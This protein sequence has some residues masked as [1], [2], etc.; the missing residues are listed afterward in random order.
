MDLPQ[1]LLELVEGTPIG[2]VATIMPDGGPHLVPVWI[3]YDG[4]HFLVAGQADKQRHVNA[5][6]DPRVALSL[7]DP[8]DIYGR[9]YLIRGEVEELSPEGGRE[10]LD[11]MSTKFVDIDEH[12]IRADRLLMKIKPTEVVDA[13]SVDLRA[14][15]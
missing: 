10:F 15:G 12:P 5:Q 11:E 4:E 7:L 3:G 13:S 9:A 14:D 2:H 8:D 1:D 6:N